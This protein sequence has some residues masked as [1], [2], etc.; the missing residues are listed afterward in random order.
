MHDLKNKN[1]SQSI[2]SEKPLLDSFYPE[3]CTHT[4]KKSYQIPQYA[5]N[6]IHKK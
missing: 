1:K 5:L 6:L 2:G 3:R 4:K